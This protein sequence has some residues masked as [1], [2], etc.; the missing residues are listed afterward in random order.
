VIFGFGKKREEQEPEERPLVMFQGAT[1]GREVDLARNARLA[2]AGLVPAKELVT[3]AL[4][5]RAHTLRVDPKGSASA[6]TFTIDGI[7]YPAGRLSKQESLA[8]TQMI[9]LLAGLEVKLRQKEQ[10]GGIKAEFDETKYTLNVRTKPTNGGVERLTIHVRDL[11]QNLE[12]PEDLGFSEHLR[13]RIR[14]LS[15]RH[16]GLLL[17]CGPPLSGTTT[18]SYAVLRTVDSYIFNI[19][20]IADTTGHTL[21]NI[22]PFEVKPGDD[23]ETSLGRCIRVDADI[24]FVNPIKSAEAAIRDASINALRDAGA[25]LA[26]G[27][28]NQKELKPWLARELGAAETR[29]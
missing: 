21:K 16:C 22:T 23:L 4:L 29:P 26:I 1:N 17:T 14:E 20:T 18:L 9:K 3:D 2:E 28:P 12:T 24:I 6:I 7:N 19:Y 11:S 13:D 15:S 27:F 10:R 25:F 5:R 8:V